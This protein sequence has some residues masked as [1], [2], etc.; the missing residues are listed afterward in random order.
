MGRI[1]ARIGFSY[2]H[3]EQFISVFALCCDSCMARG[4][5]AAHQQHADWVYPWGKGGKAA[6]AAEHVEEVWWVGWVVE[7]ERFLSTT[8]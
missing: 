2:Q 8:L 6:A 3:V 1:E 7:L 5:T 4:L